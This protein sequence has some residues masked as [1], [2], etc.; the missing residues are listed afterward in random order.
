MWS[1]ACFTSGRLRHLPF[2]TFGIYLHG[3]CDNAKIASSPCVCFL[4]GRG[5]SISPPPRRAPSLVASNVASTRFWGPVLKAKFPCGARSAVRDCTYV[6]SRVQHLWED[7]RT[8]DCRC[9]CCC[10]CCRCSCRHHETTFLPPYRVYSVHRN[11]IR[12]YIAPAD[13]SNRFAR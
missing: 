9:C 10:C 7:E 12:A 2:L 5:L 3:S 13:A 11:I 6:S 4:G 1:G 8:A